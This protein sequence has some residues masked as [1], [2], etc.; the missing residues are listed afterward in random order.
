MDSP[1]PAADAPAVAYLAADGF[2]PELLAELGDAAI[3]T[4][5]RLVLARGP[6]KPAA[7]AANVWLDLR[8]IPTP[9][10]GEAAK[11][12]KAIQRNWAL[13]PTGHFR[14]AALIE[15]KLPPVKPKPL[16][17]P[18]PAP[19][20]KLGSW[21]LWEP[22]LIYASAA[23]ASPFR[24]GEVAFV[25]DRE[26][27]PNR[28]YLKLWEALTIL[29]RRPLPGE[30]CLDLGASPGGWTWALAGLG[31]R[32]IAVDKA[33][34]DPRVAALPGVETRRESAFGLDPA[35]IGPVDWWVSDIVC[36]PARLLALVERWRASGLARNMIATIKFQA[37]TDHDAAR[38][39]A[40]IPGSRVMHL[41]HN[42]HELTWAL[43][44][45]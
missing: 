2:V 26:G 9:S 29:G 4:R 34:L 16:A 8:A 43:L 33:A 6:A 36:Y 23:C 39:F 41:H 42:K 13:F 19:S 5:D 44:T 21:T 17:F 20:A 35:T 38:E 45:P 27:P 32:V 40:A 37:A 25:E 1:N 31:A 22:D 14:R 18:A 3:E 11:A 28:A 12:L 15:A 30:R 10:I 24:H 7:W